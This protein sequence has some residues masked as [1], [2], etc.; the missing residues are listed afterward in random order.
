MVR[1]DV[2]LQPFSKRLAVPD[3][4]DFENKQNKIDLNLG[5]ALSDTVG[6]LHNLCA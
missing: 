5:F 2:E 4:G 6:I 1:A 3:P